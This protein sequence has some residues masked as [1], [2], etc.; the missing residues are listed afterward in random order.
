MIGLIGA[1][2]LGICLA[3]LLEEA[4]YELLVSDVRTSYV[5]NLN[6]KFIASPEPEVADRLKASKNITATDNNFEVIE[7][8]DTILVKLA[9]N[10]F[11]F[12]FRNQFSII[13]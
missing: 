5:H 1:G 2:R 9:I 12:H 11:L 8:C 4:G 6:Q 13:A 7:K 10:V 3:L